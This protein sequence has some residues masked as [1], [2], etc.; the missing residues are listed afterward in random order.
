M[1]NRNTW[2]LVCVVVLLAVAFVNQTAVATDVRAVVLATDAASVGLPD[3][4]FG[5]VGTPSINV[6][7]QVTFASYLISGTAPSYLSFDTVWSEAG[8]KGLHLSARR[9]T[10]PS[11]VNDGSLFNMFE[12]FMGDI[13]LSKEYGVP[14][15]NA[16]GT[17]AF[18]ASLYSGHGVWTESGSITHTVART[19]QPVPELPGREHLWVF[20]P[21]VM[22]AASATL[23]QSRIVEP[24]SYDYN[25]GLFAADATGQ[26]RMVAGGLQQNPIPGRPS[27]NTY[28]FAPDP[29]SVF[30]TTPFVMNDTGKIAFTA[31]VNVTTTT[32]DGPGVFV[33]R[34]PGEVRTLAIPGDLVPG[35]TTA[36]WVYAPELDI[37][38]AGTIA[39]RASTTGGSGVW[40]GTTSDDLHAV[41]RSGDPAPGAAPGSTFGSSFVGVEI[42]KAGQ[43]AFRNDLDSFDS[44][45]YGIWVANPDGTIHPIAIPGTASPGTTV[46]FKDTSE[47]VL[48]ALGQVAFS[49]SLYGPGVFSNNDTGIWATDV[50]GALHLVAREGDPLVVGPDVGTNLGKIRELWFKGGSGNQ[51]GRSVGFDDVGQVAFMAKT[52]TDTSLNEGVFVSNMVAVPEPSVVALCVAAAIAISCGRRREVLLRA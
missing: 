51:D 7:G 23:F 11:D 34:T 36:K 31:N 21:A 15:S 28:R 50:D 40:K 37:N 41:V 19:T 35:S 26:P 24:I 3:Q 30:S 42:N 6:L 44:L 14:Q 25:T 10:S 2:V 17:V 22:N 29:P 33:E 39:F 27:G 47:P 16:A 9:D 1:L 5:I 8:G 12:G 20:G 45:G 48:N 46:L 18:Q 4:R 43:V 49:A 52:F 32:W 13:A 38:N